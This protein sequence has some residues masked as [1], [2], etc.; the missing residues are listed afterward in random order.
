MKIHYRVC[1]NEWKKY[2]LHFSR[3]NITANFY[4]RGDSRDRYNQQHNQYNQRRAPSPERPYKLE[5]ETQEID[6]WYLLLN[7]SSCTK[8][9]VIQI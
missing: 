5:P 4:H 2:V 7:M 9:L 3:V 8:G 6:G 1:T